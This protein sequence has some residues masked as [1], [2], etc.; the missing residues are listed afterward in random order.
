MDKKPTTH[1]ERKLKQFKS[2]TRN[3]LVEQHLQKVRLRE[4]LAE[5][6]NNLITKA[7]AKIKDD[8]KKEDFYII[9]MAYFCRTIDSDYLPAELG[10]IKY[11]LQG[12]VQKQLH[13]HINPGKIPTGLAYQAQSHSKNSHE[14][15]IPPNALGLTDYDEIAKRLVNF[16]KMEKNTP[17]LLFTERQEVPMVENMLKAIL[18]NLTAEGML[19]VC[20]LPEL[21]HQLQ[22]AVEAYDK[23][24]EI[25]SSAHK[26]QQMLD[27][28]CFSYTTGISCD[29]HES[30]ELLIHCALSQCI[31]WSYTIS[32]TCCKS[33]GID[34][35]AGKHMPSMVVMTQP[36]TS[37]V[38]EDDDADSYDDLSFD[39]LSIASYA[40]DYTDMLPADVET[41]DGPVCSNDESVLRSNGLLELLGQGNIEPQ[42][43]TVSVEKK[44]NAETGNDKESLD[45]GNNLDESKKEIFVLTP[46]GRY[47]LYGNSNDSYDG[48]PW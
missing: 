12:G 35:I 42:K 43:E 15:P 22:L 39:R 4:Q 2:K 29:Y 20:S 7:C 27:V 1:L 36:S 5:L 33:L 6:K 44:N 30:N 10:V 18:G 34:L 41:Y 13:M 31:R 47:L 19:Y 25:P 48:K 16:L 21:F 46:Y 24:E 14:L 9:S 11:S 38:E 28:D 32:K 23:D 17:L 45:S 40:T 26:A 8:L 37:K 3:N